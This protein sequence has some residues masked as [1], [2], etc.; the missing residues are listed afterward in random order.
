[1]LLAFF[2]LQV[3]GVD[4]QTPIWATEGGDWQRTN[5][6]FLSLPLLAQQPHTTYTYGEPEEDT[7]SEVEEALLA[8]PLVTSVGQVVVM[9][10]SCVI[11]LM[12]DPF[13][14]GNFIPFST[15][16]PYNDTNAQP[17]TTKECEAGGMVLGEG[18]VLFFLDTRNTVVH[19]LN[20]DPSTGITWKWSST[21]FEDTYTKSI[22]A[23][24]V[25]MVIINNND[26][27]VPLKYS[28]EGND[29]FAFYLDTATGTRRD[30]IAPLPLDGCREPV[31]CGSAVVILPPSKSGVMQLSS[32]DCGIAA[33]DES[34]NNVYSLNAPLNAPRFNFEMGQ[35]SHPLYDSASGN[36]YFVN[37]NDDVFSGPQMLC[38]WN[39]AAQSQCQGW[40]Q[41]SNST[42]SGC[43]VPIP[44]LNDTPEEGITWRYSWA[45][46][47]F[48]SLANQLYLVTSGAKNEDVFGRF[49]TVSTLSVVDVT[50]GEI[51]V[52][53][54]DN[55]LFYNSAP[56]VLHG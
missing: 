33:Y 50:D 45:A 37:F 44:I 40:P 20:L 32:D 55:S 27:W 49:G 16:T 26:L 25:S 4:G 56:L 38:C 29:G 43:S 3:L 47:G 24:T 22:L 1:M 31:P 6:F 11:S 12:V 41:N 19:A 54:T 48:D 18:D 8:S 51:L 28:L 17:V 53:T 2:L 35:H 34:G 13:L 10:D 21:R 14:G 23:S 39:T 5:S 15:W 30:P 42:T 36:L 46:L 9:L 7:V 52:T